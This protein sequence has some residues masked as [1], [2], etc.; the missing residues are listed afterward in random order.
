M[1]SVL[2]RTYNTQGINK[3]QA[4]FIRLLNINKLVEFRS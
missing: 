3:I 1:P 4:F 2:V